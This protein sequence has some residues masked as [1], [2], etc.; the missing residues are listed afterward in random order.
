M[1]L[2]PSLQPKYTGTYRKRIT[3][4]C[5]LAQVITDLSI[6]YAL[7]MLILSFSMSQE[8][9]R[10]SI[11]PCVAKNRCSLDHFSTAAT[12]FISEEVHNRGT[13]CHKFNRH[14]IGKMRA[15][16]FDDLK[17]RETTAACP[18][19][20]QRQRAYKTKASIFHK[21]HTLSALCEKTPSEET[22]CA[23]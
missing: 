18:S 22:N 8:E 17:G 20:T 2:F 1:L 7:F 10:G 5:V 11:K 4:I 19:V 3:K 21:G 23:S 16:P 6:F 14:Q 15:L 13:L 12:R 9:V